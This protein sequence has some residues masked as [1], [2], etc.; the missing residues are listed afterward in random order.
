MGTKRSDRNFK[1]SV[2]QLQLTY[3][4]WFV[5]HVYHDLPAITYLT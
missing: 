4:T 5:F 2:K 1:L 3:Y